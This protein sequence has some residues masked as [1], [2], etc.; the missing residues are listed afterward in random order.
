MI[1]GIDLGTTNSLIAVWQDSGPLIIPNALGDLLTPSVVGFSD[2]GEI[3]VGR[4]AKDRML[5]HPSLTTAY[6][7]RFMGSDRLVQ[8]GEKAFR[9]EE[10]SALVL[11]KLKADAEACLGEK[12]SEAVVT[13]PAYFNENQRKATKIAGELAGI[14]VE[15]LLN[16]PTAAAL[17]YGLHEKRETQ[18]MVFDLGG[19]TFDIS[20]VEYFEGILQVHA[21]AGDNHLGG[22]DFTDVIYRDMLGHLHDGKAQE[23]VAKLRELL[24]RK[25]E[26]VKRHLTRHDSASMVLLDNDEAPYELTTDRFESLCQLLLDRISAPMQ[27]ALRDAQIKASELEQVILVGGATRMPIVRRLVTKLM[28]RFPNVDV[29]P[30]QVV[31]MG[32]C[33]Q[34]GLKARNAALDDIVLT[35][36]CPYTLGTEVS[37]EENAIVQ[38]G[39]FSP[40]IERNTFVPVSRSQKYG[41]IVKNQTAMTIG[42]YQGESPFVKDN[43]FLGAMRMA[44]P[45]GCDKD[46]LVEVRFTYDINGLLEVEATLLRT[47]QKSSITIEQNPGVLSEEDIKERLK[48]LEKLKIHPRELEENLAIVHRAQRLYEESIGE[49]RKAIGEWLADFRMVLESQ[50]EL[51]IL[52]A[53]TQLQENLDSIES[54]PWV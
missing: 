22:E 50:D 40:I 13:V 4:A 30:D 29:D 16:E 31:A 38:S 42:V 32:A 28:Q 11:K 54:D 5:T 3:I 1:V 46:E 12:L 37:R 51:K 14:K 45:P 8:L 47:K 10:L 36:V 17:A 26:L 52:P 7:K 43:I 48:A 44:L 25:A 20:V 2:Q 49:I 41:T 9:P 53:R 27:R 15:R 39:Y 23:P 21:S 24:R 34:A 6:F 18:C 35:D 33:V 19:G